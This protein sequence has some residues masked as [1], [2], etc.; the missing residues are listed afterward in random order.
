VRAV[1]AARLAG[2]VRRR[3]FAS[4]TEVTRVEITVQVEPAGGTPAPVEYR[5][6]TDTAILTA[7]LSEAGNGG[8]LS[9]SVELAGND[10][11]WLILDVKGGRIRGVEVAVWPNVEKRPGL[12]APPEVEAARVTVPARR[13]HPPVAAIQMDTS[14]VAEA[15]PEE[16]VIHFR[17]GGHRTA[18]TVRIARDVLVDLDERE[19]LAGVWLLNV[20]P[21]PAD[22]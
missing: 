8:G 4:N 12:H 9:G 20:P 13:S 6:D 5:W 17:L 2:G 1:P 19:V 16:S 11:S 21:F 7:H 10:G 22:E 3:I 14:L 15:N 18:R